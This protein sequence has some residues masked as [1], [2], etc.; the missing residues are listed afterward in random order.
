[1]VV[2]DLEAFVPLATN[3]FALTGR[4]QDFFKFLKGRVGGGGGGHTVSKRGL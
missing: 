4:S 1:M 3:H 2:A